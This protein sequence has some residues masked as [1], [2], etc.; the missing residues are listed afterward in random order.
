MYVKST[1]NN[2]DLVK[3]MQEGKAIFFKMPQYE[4][5]SPQVKNVIVSYIMSKIMIASEV[6][7]Q[8]VCE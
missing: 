7:S 1:T 2:I 8:S 4:V 5:S 3:C 6:R